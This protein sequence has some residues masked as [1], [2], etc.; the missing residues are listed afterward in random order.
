MLRRSRRRGSPLVACSFWRRNFH[1]TWVKLRRTQ[2]EHMSSGL[3]LKANIVRCSWHVSN[4]PRTDS[5]TAARPIVEKVQRESDYGFQPVIL[6]DPARTPA[7]A[8]RLRSLKS[9]CTRNSKRNDSQCEA[10]IADLKPYPK[11]KETG[12]AL[13]DVQTTAEL[14]IDA[15]EYAHRSPWAP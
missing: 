2:H 14:R 12:K 3:P 11:Y 5:C 1:T 9:R 7:R 8:A 10:M 4:V 13:A 6:D 15:K